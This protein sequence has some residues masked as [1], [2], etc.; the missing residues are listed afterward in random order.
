MRYL[1]RC[2]TFL[3]FFVP[4]AACGQ[5]REFNSVVSV[6]EQRDAVELTLQHGILRLQVCSNSVIRVTLSP[7]STIPQRPDFVVVK[8]EWAAVPWTIVQSKKDVTL[9]T[10]KL[11]V[12]IERRSG[13]IDYV[14]GDRQ[15]VRDENRCSLLLRSMVSRRFAPKPSSTSTVL[16]K[17]CMVLDNI[18]VG[19][20]TTAANQLTC[21]RK[22]PISPFRFWSRAKATAFT[23]TTLLAHASTTVSPI[24]STSV[25]KSLTRSTTSFSMVPRSTA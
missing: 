4:A 11:R 18:R 20:G 22:I 3:L 7:S 23:G 2:A 16:Q 10:A 25:L 5:W 14:T 21:R 19:S 6:R 15:L 12:V 13:A 17:A 8:H 1:L 9:S 24:I